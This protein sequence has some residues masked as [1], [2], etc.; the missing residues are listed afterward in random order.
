MGD[1]LRVGKLS[2]YVTSQRSRL[3]FPSHRG[4][5]NEDQLRLCLQINVWVA[6]NTDLDLLT[7]RAIPERFCDEYLYLCFTFRSLS[8]SFYLKSPVLLFESDCDNTWYNNNRLT[9]FVPGQPG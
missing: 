1:R 4:R 9:A 3:G 8:V 2:G 5:Y 7:T 6:G